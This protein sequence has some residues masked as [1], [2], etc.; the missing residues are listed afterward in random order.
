MDNNY[1]VWKY[2]KLI[3]TKLLLLVVVGIMGWKSQ[4][5]KEETISTTYTKAVEEGKLFLASEEYEKASNMF[6]LELEEKNDEEISKLNEQCKS[7]IEMIE[8]YT[9][10][11]NKENLDKEEIKNKVNNIV[12]LC[13]DIQNIDTESNLIKEKSE[14]ILQEYNEVE[15]NEVAKDKN[16]LKDEYI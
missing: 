2:E 1:G 15:T 10:I 6:T 14:A 5:S 12:N 3:L 8:I 7:T 11:E 16:S 9:S 13:E 4:N